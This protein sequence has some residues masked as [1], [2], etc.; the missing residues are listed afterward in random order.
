MHLVKSWA[1]CSLVLFVDLKRE[2][3][4]MESTRFQT[5]TWAGV[6]GNGDGGLA[7]GQFEQWTKPR[8]GFLKWGYQ[9]Y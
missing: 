2:I 3:P 7:V 8:L 9:G 6:V 4:Q 1:I 5:L